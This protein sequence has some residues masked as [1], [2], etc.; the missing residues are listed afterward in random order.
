MLKITQKCQTRAWSQYHRLECKLFGRLHPR[1]LP[2]PV[3]AIIRVLKQQEAELLPEN[4]WGDLL[5]TES[6]FDDSI[7][8][9]KRWQDLFIM[10]KGIKSYCGT[11]HSQE[12][13]LHLACKVIRY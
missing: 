11:D 5:A 10:S 12:T 9:Q 1:L 3:R 8:D 4:E 2:T 6:H 13:I 7:K